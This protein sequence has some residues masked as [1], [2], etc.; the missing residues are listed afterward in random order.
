MTDPYSI[1]GVPKS[2]D[3]DEI[4]RAYR[5]LAKELHPDANPGDQAAED[6]FKKVSS[7]F[8]L[9]SNTETR[10]RYDRGEIDGEGNER[11]AFHP[12]YAGAGRA[13]ARGAGFEDISDIFSDLF[14]DFR[15]RSRARK[16]ADLRFRLDLD[17]LDA[18]KG[19]TKRVTLP[20]GRTLD[21]RTPPG[22]TDG[23]TLR[24]AGQ[25]EP[26]V[27][28]GPPGDALV[29]LHVRP[30]KYFSRDGDDVRLDLPVS[31]AEAVKGAKVRAPTI[32]GAVEVQVPAGASSGT[33]L[34]LRG[35]GFP[36]KGGKRGDQ[37]VRVLIDLPADD[38]ALKAF[39]ADWQPP[40][41]YDPRMK[42]R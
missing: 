12:G 19:A 18:A 30:H 4:R 34:R 29:E 38:A 32:D 9:L 41:G 10:A 13:Q 6:R 20:A 27:S 1:L 2:A 39:V 26:G 37:I 35:K 3:A 42:L 16:G 24:L 22:V 11:A 36:T 28:G 7:A 8:K 15:P 33:L 14:T 5:K 17:F 31:F 21:V 40:K 23:Q 25:G